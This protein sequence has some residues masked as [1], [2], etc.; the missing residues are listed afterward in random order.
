[1]VG[2]SIINQVGNMEQLEFDFPKP[3]VS[4][5]G[6]SMLSPLKT[7]S[8]GFDLNCP[9]SLVDKV[10]R[11]MSAGLITVKDYQGNEL[12]VKVR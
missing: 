7:P 2:I 12:K 9:K 4:L 1:M 11:A 3:Y 5:T 6:G 8:I 10:L